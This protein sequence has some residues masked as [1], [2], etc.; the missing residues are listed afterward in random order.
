M[1]F[2][3]VLLVALVVVLVTTTTVSADEKEDHMNGI[4]PH[5]PTITI[6]I[7]K[8]KKPGF[9]SRTFRGA[10]QL[11][12]KMA[13]RRRKNDLLYMHDPYRNTQIWVPPPPPLPLYNP[14]LGH[15]VPIGR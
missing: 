9:F 7:Q 14:A 5:M 15:P 1:K 13:N 8:E 11:L 10:G 4:N 2:C 3:S 6:D 12:K